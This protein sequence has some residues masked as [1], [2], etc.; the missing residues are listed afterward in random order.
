MSELDKFE[1]KIIKNK[2][3]INF[4]TKE[5]RCYL[6]TYKQG[7]NRCQLSGNG[8]SIDVFNIGWLDIEPKDNTKMWQELLPHPET[9]ARPDIRIEFNKLTSCE[10]ITHGIYPDFKIIRCVK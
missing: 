4:E 6:G 1:M 7:V 8:K 5:I 10:I 9:P 2:G 3:I